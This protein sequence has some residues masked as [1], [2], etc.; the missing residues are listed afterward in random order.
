VSCEIVK[1]DGVELRRGEPVRVSNLIL[2]PVNVS[3]TGPEMPP[4]GQVRSAAEAVTAT[5]SLSIEVT[6]A[7][8]GKEDSIPIRTALL[9]SGQTPAERHLSV[10][11]QVPIDDKDRDAQ[12]MRYIELLASTVDKQSPP[13]DP[14]ILDLYKSQKAKATLA[15]AFDRVFLENRVGSFDVTCTYVSKV[16]GSWN[17]E[18]RAAPVRIDIVFAGHFFEQPQFQQKPGGLGR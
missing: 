14:M 18:V 3:F 2:I 1:G 15:H 12:E 6:R 8:A 5:S 11:L 10:I 4:V 16:P 9:G 13:L 7:G 17:G